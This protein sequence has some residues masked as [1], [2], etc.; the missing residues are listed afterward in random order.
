MKK[1]LITLV[2]CMVTVVTFAQEA[3]WKSSA[4]LQ[5][6]GTYKVEFK[7]SVPAGWHV[8]SMFTPDGGPMQ[9]S[10]NFNKGVE[11]VGKAVESPEPHKAFDEIF[12][13]DV[14]SF[15][16]NFTITQ[17]VKFTDD[18]A[19]AIAGYID[20]QLCQDGGSCVMGSYDFSVP[21]KR[22]VKA[23]PAKKETKKVAEPVKKEEVKSEEV[24]PVAESVAEPVAPAV[25]EEVVAEP[26]EKE[27]SLWVF[28]WLAFA[29]GLAAVIM[30][31]VFPMIPMTVSFFMH[32]DADK[33]KAKMKA[34][35]YAFS[36]IFIYTVIG[37]IIS[38]LLGADFTN[39]LSTNWV[40][41]LFFFVIFMIFAASFLG[42]FEIVLPSW[43]VNK[44]DAQADKGGYIGAFFMAFT[45]VLVSFSCTAPIV[46][47][48]LVEAARG[49]VLRPII[50]M[51]GFSLA[52]ALPFG[53]F[54]FFPSKLSS[55]PKSGGWLNSVK[56]VLGFIEI[57]LGFKFLMV[58]DQTYHLGI[59]DREIYIAIWIVVFSLIG[60]YLLG[61]F[62]L[63]H[64]DAD[65]CEKPLGI[66][67]ISLVIVV[68]TFV[69]YMIPGMFGAPLKALAGYLP[70]QETIDFD[71]NRI[72]R[73]NVR[74]LRGTAVSSN[75]QQRE[76]PKYADFL[77]LAHGL[78]GY[79]DY[80]QALRVA[81]AE[82]KPLFLDFT[83][84]GCVNCREMEQS[85]WSDPRVIEILT[86]EY[87]ICALYVDDKTV[88]PESEQYTGK[89]GKLKNT[90]GK[91]NADF[92]INNF[93]SNAQ[94]NYIL[95]NSRHGED[96]NL[97]PHVMMPA[98]GYNLDANAFVEFL[99]AGVEK[100]KAAN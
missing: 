98:R 50:G 58:I 25:T 78:E 71:I 8:Y 88:L 28:F 13:V 34:L 94:P 19:N 77:H 7:C 60:L 15:E 66:L 24:A 99:K 16:G 42:A 80:E 56:V 46:G 85:V 22:E 49:S 29:G 96:E 59:L 61:K 64:D 23:A 95:L 54:A 10:L 20:Y 65:Y 51:F 93:D 5:N 86:N 12:E 43:M 81:K 4:T 17:I 6:D 83:G 52:V 89:D 32:S 53:F 48:I 67:R 92:Q 44:T 82:N 69:V 73:E 2:L 62:K 87:I 76:A 79:F 21:V 26:E 30:P 68:F 75:V 37:L 55:L 90:L 9:T 70:P 84:H 100:Y 72:V 91:K 1:L 27:D 35:F 33:K 31:C 38:F 36:I 11:V 74:S 39:W 3:T 63:Q 45:L 47:T 18:K 97:R 57:A 40:P 41:N 14:W